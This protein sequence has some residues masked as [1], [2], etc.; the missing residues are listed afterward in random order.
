M[1][2]IDIL[3]VDPHGAVKSPEDLRDFQYSEIGHSSAPFDWSVGYDVE[4]DVTPIVHTKNQ[5]VSGSCGGQ[6]DGYYGATLSFIHDKV[7]DEKSAKFTYAPIAAPGGGVYGRDVATRSTTAG[8]GSESLTPSYE[9]GN[10]PSEAFMELKSDITAEA[11]AQAKKDRALSYAFVALNI[12]SIAQAIR[13]NKGVRI[14]LIGTNN[15]TWLSTMPTPPK[16]GE[17]PWFHYVYGCKAKE[18]NGI[19]YIGFKNSWGSSVGDNGVQWLSEEYVN[20]IFHAPTYSEQ[21]VWEVTTYVFNNN[22]V[23]GF[24][25]DFA[26]NLSFGQTSQEIVALQ[27]ALQLEGVFPS[28]INPTTSGYYGSITAT[29]VL[30]FRAKYG[31]PS[32]TDTK[33]HS[34][35]PLT[36]TELNIL[37][38]K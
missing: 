6:S 15:G 3:G 30:K 18:I 33:G 13:D 25:H 22:T 26:T 37:Y 28:T 19:K 24:S 14:G 35:G 38:N 8:W 1:N 10:P 16:A 27:T 12:D 20:T 34:V 32:S 5:G 31:I 7:Y 21:A 9:N 29:A 2:P 23:S 17:T 36:R 4:T 11:I